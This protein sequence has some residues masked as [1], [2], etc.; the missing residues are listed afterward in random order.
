VADGDGNDSRRRLIIVIA[1][2][3]VI[4]AAVVGAT[5][6]KRS[7]E[8]VRSA[9]AL[10]RQLDRSQGLDNAL[11]SL[12][13]ETL[14]PQAKALADAVAVAPGEIVTDL[15]T[16]SAFVSAVLREVDAA[17]AP[18]RRRAFADALA[19]RQ[20][21]IDS[22]TAA[23]QSLERWTADNCGLVLGDATT[24]SVP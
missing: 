21:E 13:P 4:V 7:T 12:D 10:C 11:T 20:G 3:A 1:V 5:L 18:D 16:V 8:P 15:T 9:D 19:N 23:G 2:G 6:F 22:V 17:P 24:V 14:G